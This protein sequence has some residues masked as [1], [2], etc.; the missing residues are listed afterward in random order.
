MKV[1]TQLQPWKPTQ[2]TA[3]RADKLGSKD[4]MDALDAQFTC[5]EPAAM[6][7]TVSAIVAGDA[8]CDRP[9]KTSLFARR[10]RPSRK[11]KVCERWAKA[12]IEH[13]QQEWKT[14]AAH[15]L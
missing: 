3:V 5:C 7:R 8:K 6:L 11:R 15:S 12:T 14:V 1:G 9:A 13:C 10:Q 4:D 2:Q